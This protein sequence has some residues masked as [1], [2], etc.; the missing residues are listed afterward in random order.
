MARNVLHTG[1]GDPPVPEKGV[2]SLARDP[3]RAPDWR[4]KEIAK[5]TSGSCC[6]IQ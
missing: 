4:G 6:R 1:R 3:D 5:P 2:D